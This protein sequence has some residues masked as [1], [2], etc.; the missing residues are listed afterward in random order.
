MNLVANLKIPV[1]MYNT[2]LS[3]FIR[4]DATDQPAWNSGLLMW[5]LV[6]EDQLRC[7]VRH[8]QHPKAIIKSSRIAQKSWNTL[9]QICSN[10]MRMSIFKFHTECMQKLCKFTMVIEWTKQAG[11]KVYFRHESQMGHAIEPFTTVVYVYWQ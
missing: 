8:N 6:I 1:Q 4:V 7:F 3:C 5:L 10:L 2:E 9:P 11:A